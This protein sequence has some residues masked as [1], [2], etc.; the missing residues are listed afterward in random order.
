MN[1]NGDNPATKKDLVKLKEELLEAMQ[2]GD[3]R[4]KDELVEVIRGV[5]T[6]LLSAFYGYTQSTQKHFTDLDQSSASLRERLGSLESRIVELE[7][8]I[9]FPHFK[10]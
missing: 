4:L 2:Q 1:N 8:R 6:H 7:R 5:E 9:N 3:A 10:P